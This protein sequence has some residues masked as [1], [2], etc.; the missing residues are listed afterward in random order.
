[1][2]AVAVEG[3][4]LLGMLGVGLSLLNG[5]RAYSFDVHMHLR[6]FDLGDRSLNPSVVRVPN[7]R[8]HLY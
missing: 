5:R 4:D 7:V 3:S 8:M 1:M 2:V 6:F